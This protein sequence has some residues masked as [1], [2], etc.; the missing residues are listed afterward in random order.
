MVMFHICLHR[1]FVAYYINTRQLIAGYLAVIRNIDQ[2]F[3]ENVLIIV[4]PLRDV[5]LTR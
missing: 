1:K 4:Y 3:S 5:S 2:H